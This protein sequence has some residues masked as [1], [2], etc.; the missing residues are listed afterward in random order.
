MRPGVRIDGATPFV[1]LKDLEEAGVAEEVDREG[2]AV[3]YR[4]TACD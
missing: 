3:L 4:I 2:D 1:G